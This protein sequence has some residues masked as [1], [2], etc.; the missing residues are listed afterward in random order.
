MPGEKPRDDAAELAS[1]AALG[2]PV[3]R[4]LYEV[5]AAADEPI[6]REQAARQADVPVHT[7][8]FHLDRLVA[9][10]LL[11]VEYR[12]LTGRTGPGAGRPAKLYRRGPREL[13]VSLPPRQYDLLSRILATAV[14]AAGRSPLPVR[15]LADEVARREGEAFGSARR[16]RGRELDRVA[17]ALGDGGYEPQLGRG[18][19]RLRNCPFHHT[20]R[21]QTELVCS[22][23]VA[24]VDG[25][26]AGLG[27]TSVEAALEPEPD[28]CCVV[29]RSHAESTRSDVE[30][31]V[32]GSTYG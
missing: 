1:I 24:Y 32:S 19:V 30:S 29:V 25:V 16:G 28:R 10:G 31:R 9:E 3:R 2:E 13:S 7:A 5:V 26:C 12:R 11:D 18:E 4:R 14:A 22:L 8:R 6:G 20:A 21:E 17:A 27:C 23:N 15:R